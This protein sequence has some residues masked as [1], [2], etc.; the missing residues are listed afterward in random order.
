MHG[1]R[2][3][4]ILFWLLLMTISY[5]TVMLP[6]G[7]ILDNPVLL[8]DGPNV[9]NID[10]GSAGL[11]DDSVGDSMWVVIGWVPVRDVYRQLLYMGN[12]DLSQQALKKVNKNF[13]KL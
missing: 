7:Q 4:A 9:I 10:G 8:K 6:Q 5:L 2:S 11:G 3:T 1:Y 12:Q 13:C